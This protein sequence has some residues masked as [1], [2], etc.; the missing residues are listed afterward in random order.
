MNP[1]FM[2]TRHEPCPLPAL[3]RKRE[4]GTRFRCASFTLKNPIA[5]R[6]MTHQPERPV[7][8][9]CGPGRR[10]RKGQAVVAMPM[11]WQQPRTGAFM[12][13]GCSPRFSGGATFTASGRGR[14]SYSTTL[15]AG[16]A[17]SPRLGRWKHHGN[18]AGAA[19]LQGHGTPV[20]AA[21]SPRLGGGNITASGRGAPPVPRSHVGAAPSPRFSGG[22]NITA[23]GRGRPSCNATLH[24]GA[25]PSPRS[26]GGGNITASGRGRP[27]CN[28]TLHVGA[29]PSPRFSGGGT[30]TASGRGRP[31]C[32]ATPHV[33][34][35]PSPRFSGGG[36]F[37]ASGRGRPSYKGAAPLWERRPRRDCRVIQ[38]SRHRAGAT[39][40]QQR[41]RV[42]A[43]ARGRPWLR[44]Q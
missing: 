24:V 33:G 30:I 29:A 13:S 28:A 37:T 1:T 43:P 6:H 17:P 34:A 11:N 8:L 26:S 25:A 4:R 38:P 5:Y 39:L 44:Y 3:S 18:R 21:P 16:A 23:S 41:P 14:P 19:L 9:P 36:T 40:L 22:G 12:P 42:G 7:K 31:S 27:S 20:G 35:A 10:T 15:H 32:N 2:A